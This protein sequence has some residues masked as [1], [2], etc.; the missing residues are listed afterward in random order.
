[1]KWLVQFIIRLT[2]LAEAEGR[3]FKRNIFQLVLSLVMVIVV[4]LL[5]IAALAFF[6]GAVYIVFANLVTPAGALAILGGLALLLA[7]VGLAA[8]IIVRDQGPGP[9][10]Q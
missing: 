6:G 3:T 9:K 4:G 2:E 5:L 1:M 10:K 8:A 7:I